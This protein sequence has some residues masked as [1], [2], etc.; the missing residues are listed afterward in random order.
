MIIYLARH[1]STSWNRIRKIQGWTD[2]DLD[3]KGLEMARESGSTLAADHISFDR[4][5]SSPL[6]R[7][8][9]TAAGFRGNATEPPIVTDSRLKELDFG[10]YEG[11]TAE[12]CDTMPGSY[13]RYF[14]TEPEKYRPLGGESFE[15]LC[16]RAADFLIRVIEP[17]ADGETPDLSGT[18]ASD[19]KLPGE[20]RVLIT[21]HGT[22]NHALLMHITG[23]TDMRKFWGDGLQPN[24]SVEILTRRKGLWKT[25]E[26]KIFYDP[27]LLEN[28]KADQAAARR[29]SSSGRETSPTSSGRSVTVPSSVTKQGIPTPAPRTS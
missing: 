11:H 21:A 18:S 23:E 25:G 9:E 13:F 29:Y 4:I 24:C 14:H 20:M 22:L 5:W 8:L 15:D 28:L 2:I 10:A 3:E 27:R 16:R 26:K 17:L 1:G 6:K 7:A 12:E 19:G